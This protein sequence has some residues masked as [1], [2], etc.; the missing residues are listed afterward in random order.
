MS[1]SLRDT[2][3]SVLEHWK[4]LISIARAKPKIVNIAN[5]EAV[6]VTLN[7]EESRKTIID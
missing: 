1:P 5:S 6:A 2:H 4:R 7:F 3:I